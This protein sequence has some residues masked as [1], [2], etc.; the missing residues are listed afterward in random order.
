MGIK[1]LLSCRSG[2][3]KLGIAQDDSH[4]PTVRALHHFASIRMLV[5]Y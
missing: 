1:S 3:Y 5:R 2:K 4:L